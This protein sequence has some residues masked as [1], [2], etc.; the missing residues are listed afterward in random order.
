[1]AYTEPVH[2]SETN[3]F[4]CGPDYEDDIYTVDEFKDICYGRGFLDYDGF[5]HPV[6]N[7]KSDPYIIIK[8]SQLHA[9][10]ED[11]THIVWFNR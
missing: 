3:R 4:G 8:P 7:K 1:M 10:P 11:A 9:I 5:G 6:K 2:F